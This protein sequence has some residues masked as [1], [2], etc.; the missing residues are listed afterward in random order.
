MASPS[1]ALASFIQSHT[2]PVDALNDF[3]SKNKKDVIITPPKPS[4][5]GMEKLGGQP[6][7][8][9]QAPPVP[10]PTGINTATSTS[11]PALK[12]KAASMSNEDVANYNSAKGVP[13]SPLG[14]TI[15]GVSRAVAGAKS[16][17][18]GTDL[19][20]NEYPRTRAVRDV[21]GGTAEALKPT[22]VGPM[23]SAPLRTL[24]SMGLG[25]VAQAGTEA[26][27]RALG[28]NSDTAGLAG[29]IV[30]LGTGFVAHE[31][32]EL[33]A[34]VGRAVTK[35]SDAVDTTPPKQLMTQALRPRASQ[36]G[37]DKSV[38]RSMP[39]LNTSSSQTKKPIVDVDSL[40]SNARDA[41]Q[42]VWSEYKQLMGDSG[43]P[44]VDANPIA[45]A[46]NKGI[47]SATMLND[48]PES[49]AAK[50]AEF[51]AYRTKIPLSK[52]EDE[53][54]KANARV[55]NLEGQYP[56]VKSDTLRK[57]PDMAGIFNA[58]DAMRDLLYSELDKTSDTG[59]AR[60]LKMRYGALSDVEQ[61]A[62]R[63]KIVAE[64]QAPQS[65]MQQYAR[66]RSAGDL[67]AGAFNAI[68][69]DV[70]S[71]LRQAI[72]GTVDPAAADWLRDQNSTNG[73]IAKAFRK[74][75]G[76][77]DI[78]PARPSVVEPNSGVIHTPPPFRAFS[79][80]DKTLATTPRNVFSGV[81]PN[82]GIVSTK[83]T[84]PPFNQKQLPA[85]TTPYGVSGVTVPDI[86]GAKMNPPSTLDKGPYSMPQPHGGGRQAQRPLLSA[87]QAGN[88][89]LNLPQGNP[90]LT[91]PGEASNLNPPS[92]ELPPQLSEEDQRAIREYGKLWDQFR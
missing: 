16:L 60:N 33:P 32:P 56:N 67:A 19:S 92:Q 54:Q 70:K 68:T 6:P 15:P 48:S 4:V 8:V 41:K 2:S 37:F 53:L 59:A 63:R 91:S 82:T 90:T 58:A 43:D 26:T 10:L 14:D 18:T 55:A 36:L 25:T 23:A 78:A 3:L 30:G 45:D 89:P 40:L 38:N 74:Y 17:Y 84:V 5:P 62:N 86:M 76:Q 65:M 75:T 81:D 35:I 47:D 1:D 57:N 80:N 39:D 34:K 73:L 13:D 77:A 22:I 7:N 88:P 46:A 52:L 50:K 83:P 27:A 64:R 29:D 79:G 28:I 44:L 9:T 31:A 87:P 85:P 21:I 69:G 20:G 11:N 42:R 61:T 66:I 72:K 12:A 51:D 24:A 71:G 49:V